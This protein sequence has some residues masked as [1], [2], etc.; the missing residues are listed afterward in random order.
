MMKVRNFS[1]AVL[2]MF[3]SCLSV[4][5]DEVLVIHLKS[6]NAQQISYALANKPVITFEGDN[7][8]VYDSKMY[9]T[10]SIPLAQL[11][12]YELTKSTTD[13]QQLQPESPKPV[14]ANG[15]VVFSQLTAGSRVSVYAMDG[16]LIHNYT[17]D[18]SGWVDVNLT[19]LPKGVYVINSPITNIKIT[20]R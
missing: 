12:Y 19:T 7:I 9:S 20:N 10:V 1:L 5:A 15:H 11:A 16:K 18:S 3:L 4:Q 14:I 17:A 2:L 6:N 13:I 8:L